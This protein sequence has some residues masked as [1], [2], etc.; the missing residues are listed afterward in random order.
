MAITDAGGLSVTSAL[1]V[2]VPATA[3]APTE[4]SSKGEGVG[5]SG[6]DL[7]SGLALAVMGLWCVGLGVL[8]RV[9]RLG[10]AGTNAEQ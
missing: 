2:E 8:R 9:Q 1:T 5:S 6:C 7:G 10:K 3:F 4:D